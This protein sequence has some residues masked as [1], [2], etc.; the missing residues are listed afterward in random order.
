MK[1]L[2]CLTNECFE[3][4]KEYDS[5]NSI[6]I[7]DVSQKDVV[8]GVIHP[9]LDVSSEREM[10]LET[11]LLF[12]RISIDKKYGSLTG[13]S[14]SFFQCSVL[15]ICSYIH[16]LSDVLKF[17]TSNVE[18]W[19]SKRVKGNNVSI[20]YFMAE[21]ETQG[22]FLYDRLEVFTP[23][24]I[25]VCKSHRINPKFKKTSIIRY[26]LIYNFLRVYSVL[27]IRFLK[28]GVKAIKEAEKSAN[29]EVELIVATRSLNQTEYIA[30]FLHD[31]N[32][33]VGFIAGST[34]FDNGEN[35]ST[36]RQNTSLSEKAVIFSSSNY[37][38]LSQ[39]PSYLFSL[40][41]ILK[42]KRIRIKYNNISLDYTQAFKEIFVMLPSLNVY[43]KQLEE[44]LIGRSLSAKVFV[45]LELKSPHAY[46]ESQVCKIAG[47]KCIHFMHCDIEALALPNP[48]FGD[49]F[50]ADSESTAI[51]LRE[52]A[53]ESQKPKIIHIG[54]IKNISP[55]LRHSKNKLIVCIFS[56]VRD[57]SKII[58]ILKFID[59]NESTDI[60]NII[61]KLHPRDNKKYYSPFS[62]RGL[63][64]L[65]HGL[66]SK[67]NLLEKIDLA[68]TFPSGVVK[69]LIYNGMPLVLIKNNER[70]SQ[71]N[72]WIESYIGCIE[73][74]TKLY[75]LLDNTE[76]IFSG[77]E[78]YRFEYFEINKIITDK[79]RVLKS[80]AQLY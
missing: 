74:H 4:L 69:E 65:D 51:A 77:F 28:S 56:S 30:P 2:I 64:I 43:Q 66:M 70:V 53:D 75:S 57:R 14:N 61:L 39:I 21:Y 34:F 59:L 72:Y 62:L 31:Y 80:F 63:T 73:N 54:S 38:S 46:V 41:N 47:I 68:V 36:I 50:L 10:A 40:K 35:L 79:E 78:K 55:V 52:K 58:E 27:F 49:Y 17:N 45:S 12:E 26:Q 37:S 67:T 13:Y 25:D 29:D 7:G 3:I 6:F 8:G 23:Y 9:K 18:V 60:K 20:P 22:K 11:K 16:S 71:Y 33:K 24:L 44:N 42:Q 76:L 1:I 15:P 48:V 32:H 19:F 5:V